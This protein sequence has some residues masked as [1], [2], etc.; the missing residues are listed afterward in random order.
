M[1]ALYGQQ[2]VFNHL[3]RDNIIKTDL[4][5]Q[6]TYVQG[7]QQEIA[8]L[9]EHIDW[10]P[11]WKDDSRND[12]TSIAL[13]LADITKYLLCLWQ[14]FGFQYDEMLRWIEQKSDIVEFRATQRFRYPPENQNVLFVDLDG[15]IADWRRGFLEWMMT[16]PTGFLNCH[17]KDS[18]KSLSMDMDFDWTYSDYKRL[19]DDFEWQGG[20]ANLPPFQDAIELLQTWQNSFVQ[21]YVVVCTARPVD[22]ARVYYDTFSWLDTY[23]LTA[24]EIHMVGDERVQLA[25]EMKDRGNTVIM[26][27]DNPHLAMRAAVNNLHVVMRAFPYNKLAIHYNIHRTSDFSTLKGLMK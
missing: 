11:R 14:A 25:M 6:L 8:E 13:E 22:I 12:Q 9:L 15:T 21:P 10:N 23:Q 4:E 24:H 18:L 19:K 16:E 3:I 17:S 20:Y 27:E 2:Q 7:L 5:W 1:R 26:L